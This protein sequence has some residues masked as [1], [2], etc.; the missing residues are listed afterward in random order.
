V[1]LR[2]HGASGNGQSVVVS[3]AEGPTKKKAE[4]HAAR[5]ALEQLRESAHK[6]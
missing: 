2:V 3:R 1:E 6:E 4:Q 5:Q